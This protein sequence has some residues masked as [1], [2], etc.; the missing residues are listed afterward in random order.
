MDILSECLILGTQYTLVKSTDSVTVLDSEGNQVLQEPVTDNLFQAAQLTLTRHINYVINLLPVPHQIITFSSLY[1]KE[2]RYQE[3]MNDIFSDT[4]WR[5]MIFSL[6]K[7]LNCY[8]QSMARLPW[9]PDI[10]AE[11]HCDICKFSVLCMEV[12][13]WTL[14]WYSFFDF[15]DQT[16]EFILHTTKHAREQ[17]KLMI[18]KDFLFW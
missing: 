8:L 11:S 7:T 9:K 3:K 17:K 10:P 2:N 15:F 18:S 16:T 4:S 14:L 12:R 1:V 5:E 13:I 6:T